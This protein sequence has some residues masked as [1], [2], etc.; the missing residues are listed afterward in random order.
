MVFTVRGVVPRDA[1]AVK[2][3]I[4]RPKHQQP[5]ADD[6]L[7]RSFGA[8]EL[9]ADPAA[10]QGA[11]SVLEGVPARGAALRRPR[12]APHRVRHDRVA[13]R[14]QSSP[15]MGGG[16]GGGGGEGPARRPLEKFI[17]TRRLSGV[18][19]LV[20]VGCRGELLTPLLRDVGRRDVAGRSRRWFHRLERPSCDPAE[21]ARD[22][23][24]GPG[25]GARRVIAR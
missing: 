10:N 20:G 19:W 15:S 18:P 6:G 7:E 5:A 2:L 12:L 22:L 3:G 4:T 23:G 9:D 11:G 16:G 24:A 14:S 21:E 8:V 13:V 25:A 1:P 17:F